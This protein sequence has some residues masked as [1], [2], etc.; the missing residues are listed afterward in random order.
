MLYCAC[1][2]DTLKVPGNTIENRIY[3]INTSSATFE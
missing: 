3:D 1:D 2:V